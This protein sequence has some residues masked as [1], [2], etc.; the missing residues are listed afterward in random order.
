MVAKTRGLDGRFPCDPEELHQRLFLRHVH[1]ED[2]TR[3]QDHP[4]AGP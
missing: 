1:R 3:K 4:P 2:R